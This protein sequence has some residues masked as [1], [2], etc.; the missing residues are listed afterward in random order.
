[1][2]SILQKLEIQTKKDIELINIT[3]HVNSAVFQSGCQLGI[4]HIT[5]MHTTTGITVN[6][7]LPDIE[8]DIES[9]LRRLV[10]EDSHYRHARFL[11]TD[12]QTAVNATAHLRSALLGANL[13][14]PL[15][16][17]QVVKGER[18][19]I[20]FVELDGPQLRRLVIQILG[21]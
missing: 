18:Q 1:M 8:A 7:G 4:V 3:D 2:K 10:L 14:F 17:G 5:T 21:Y 20:Y 11:H 9:L 16:D 15:S 6:E 19:T 13:S 12:G